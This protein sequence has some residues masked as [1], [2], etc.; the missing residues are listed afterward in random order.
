MPKEILP[1]AH[2]NCDADMRLTFQN[3]RFLGYRCFQKPN[4]HNFRYD[5]N[6]QRWE[7]IIIKTKP[8]IGY[9]E[10]PHETIFEEELVIDSH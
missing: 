8:I 1:C 10:S 2:I 5:I 3:D 7:K 9:K 4:S 6:R